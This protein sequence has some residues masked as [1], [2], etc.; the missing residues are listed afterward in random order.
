MRKIVSSLL[1]DGDW[2]RPQSKLNGA[3]P[4]DE[5]HWPAAL[6]TSPKRAWRRTSF[7]FRPGFGR[8]PAGIGQESN[9]ERQQCA[10]AAMGQKT[11]VPNANES[12]G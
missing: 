12:H 7:F 4:F 9:A 1:R 8:S 5:D 11:E 6:R 2:R 3:Q 10:A